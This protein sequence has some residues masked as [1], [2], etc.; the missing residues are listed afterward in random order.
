MILALVGVGANIKD[1]HAQSNGTILTGQQA[2][3]ASAV[4]LT[5]P[6]AGTICIKALAANAINVYLG[7]PG[8]TTSTG[9]EMAAGNAYCGPTAHA[10]NFYVVAATTGAS[11]SWILSN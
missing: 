11:V 5:G 3:T 2:V 9:M 7:G 8:V 4:A 1:A 6:G 10:N